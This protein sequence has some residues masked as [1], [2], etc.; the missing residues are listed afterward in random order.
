MEK[1]IAGIAKSL[2]DSPQD[3]SVQQSEEEDR[4]VLELVVAQADLG[5][6]IG[7]QGRTVRA[8]RHLLAAAAAKKGKVSRLEIRE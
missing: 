5:K 1:L 8:M 4:V 6:V 7:K 2:V 3:V